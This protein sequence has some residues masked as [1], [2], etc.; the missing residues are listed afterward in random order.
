MLFALK[1]M[2]PS[3]IYLVRGN[4][5]S[6][7]GLVLTAFSHTP[8]IQTSAQY[9]SHTNSHTNLRAIQLSHSSRAYL[10]AH[11]QRRRLSGGGAA[12]GSARPPRR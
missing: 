11:S 12:P 10:C 6:G 2:Y 5:E 1:L 9:N 7:A 8:L 3:R 4:H